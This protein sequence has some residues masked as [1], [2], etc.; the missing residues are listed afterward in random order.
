MK[1]SQETAGDYRPPPR[2]SQCLRTISSKR[3]VIYLS[4]LITIY[5]SI[6]LSICA[7]LRNTDLRRRKHVVNINE[8]VI[9]AHHA[10][11]F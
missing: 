2:A 7:P 8:R 6:E 4:I 11:K 5:L 1:L 9:P 10:K 3:A